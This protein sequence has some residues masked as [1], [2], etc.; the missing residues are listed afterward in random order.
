MQTARPEQ[1]RAAEPQFR[2]PHALARA[3]AQLYRL[4]WLVGV[5]EVTFFLNSGDTSRVPRSR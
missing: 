1:K 2:R 3:S 4:T 5:V